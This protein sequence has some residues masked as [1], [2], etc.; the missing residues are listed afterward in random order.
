MKPRRKIYFLVICM[1]VAGGAFAAA[2]APD[3]AATC[4][5]CHGEQGQGEPAALVPRLAGLQRD[6]LVKQL[7]DFRAGNRSNEAMNGIAASLQDAD[8]EALAS[9]Y[10][11]LRPRATSVDVK[12]SLVSR[13]RTLAERGDWSRTIPACFRC[14]GDG[15]T[16][17]GSH[18]PALAGQHREYLERQLQAWKQGERSNDPI[19]LMSSIAGRMTDDDIAAVAAYL[20]SLPPQQD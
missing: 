3:A 19:D 15:A 5:G 8:I 2:D 17:V 16:G 4:V 10:A 9:Y 1:A 11:E 12:A 13:G 7:R 20:A 6:Y 14:H 18:M